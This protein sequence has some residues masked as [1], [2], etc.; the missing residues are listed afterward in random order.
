MKSKLQ[1]ILILCCFIISPIIG[2]A[3]SGTDESQKLIVKYK[4]DSVEKDLSFKEIDTFNEA[5]VIEVEAHEVDAV[6]NNLEKDTSVEFVEE[7]KQYSFFETFNDPLYETYQAENIEYIQG[8]LAWDILK[9]IN[10]HLIVAVIDSGVD[11]NH[12]DLKNNIVKPYNAMNPDLY[13]VDDVGHG[14]HVAG[15]IG[16][17]TNNGIGIS[18]ISKGVDI[19]PVKVGD[20][21]SLS[22]FDVAKGII[23][24][25]D[26]GANI[27]NISIGGGYSQ[28]VEDAC[29]YANSKGVLVIAAAGNEATSNETYPAALESVIG[30]GAVDSHNDTLTTFSNYGQWVS[31]AAPGQNIYSTL[32]QGNYNYMSGTSM[33]SPMVASLASLIKMHAPTLSHQ[34]VRWMMESSSKAF[35]GSERLENGRIDALESLKLYDN[36][37]RLYGPTSVETSN[38]IASEGWSQLTHHTLQPNDSNL[39]QRL[40]KVDGSFV[41]LASNQ[42]FPD[43]LAAS[44][45]ASKL[46]APILLTFPAKLK[47]ATINELKELG[48]T[49]VILLGGKEAISETIENG[50]IREGFNIERINGSHRYVTA[51]Q[52]NNY[53]ANQGGT[54]IVANGEN[55]PDA[56]SIASYSGKF[57]YP[58]VFVKKDSIPAETEAF[59][60]K[61]NFE[62]SIVVGGTSVI[63]EQV[64]KSLPNPTRIAGNN[65]YETNVKVN[66]YFNEGKK[67]TGFI[68]ATGANFPDALSGGVL[69][70]KIGY[71]LLLVDQNR[72]L[73]VTNTYIK[74]Q[75]NISEED[76]GMYVLGG[77]VA[78]T[79]EIVWGID[80]LL[81]DAYYNDLYLQNMSYTSTTSVKNEHM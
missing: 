43:S 37:A 21:K 34:Q 63:S 38:Q 24:A 68:F 27:I 17:E 56:L 72:I 30:V 62:K 31:L 25:V 51:V 13:P 77:K 9:P 26:N 15:I 54:V 32:P 76:L 74:N 11:R 7:E 10:K 80:K 18:S 36:Y 55:Y 1:I 2:H 23:Y 20:K 79:S 50:L 44:A 46:D 41:I 67:V 60:K 3:D 70:N 35:R 45:L 12:P 4:D 71:P 6:K 52:I 29:E 58:I 47:E 81:Y 73:S 65:R 39:N 8:D 64:K 53:I 40:K 75:V 59:L 33:A 5:K 78:V 49:D 61:Y 42:S 69:S 19:M 16:A 14:T 66:S 57:Q 48:A 22:T 28:I